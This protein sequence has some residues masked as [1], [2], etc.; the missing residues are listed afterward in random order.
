MEVT[1]LLQRVHAGDRDAF[2]AVI[3]LVYAELKK[4]A[5]AHLRRERHA[6]ALQTTALVHEAFLR[7]AGAQHPSYAD[8]SHFYGIASRLL[9]QILLDAAR[10]RAAGKRG[11]GAEVAVADLPDIGHQPDAALLA[12][13]EALEALA[14]ADPLKAQLI[15]M[16]YFAGMTAEQS[17]EA[18][19]LPVHAIRRDLRLAQAWLRREMSRH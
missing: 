4:L 19:A 11:G 10:A 12:M 15:E 17:A 18:L 7:L 9:R 1:K 14:R 16:R 5:S 6:E 2:N 3:P 8:R 13:D